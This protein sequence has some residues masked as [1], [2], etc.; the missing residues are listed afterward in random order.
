MKNC[1]QHSKSN[2]G[3]ILRC[4]HPGLWVLGPKS[5]SPAGNTEVHGALLVFHGN[6]GKTTFPRYVL[7]FWFPSSILVH[8][9]PFFSFFPVCLLWDSGFY[10]FLPLGFSFVSIFLLW[11]SWFM[12]PRSFSFFSLVFGSC[13]AKPLGTRTCRSVHTCSH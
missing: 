5:W 9:V 6:P 11:N 3:W 7:L 1:F 12:F 2:L 8:V 10:V 13:T 4:P